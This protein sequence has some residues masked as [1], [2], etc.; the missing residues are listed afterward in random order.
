MTIPK[1]I[2]QTWKD[3]NIPEQWKNAVETVKGLDYEYR[4]WTDASMEEFVKKHH[5]NFYNTYTSYKYPI[6]KCDSSDFSCYIRMVEFISIW[7]LHVN[8]I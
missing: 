6:Q 5:P 8:E 1:I 4:L 2:H 7:I 3:S